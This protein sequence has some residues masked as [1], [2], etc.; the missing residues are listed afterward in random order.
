MGPYTNVDEL[1][2][3][4]ETLKQNGIATTLIRIRETEK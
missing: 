2:R 1:N 4:R 3:I